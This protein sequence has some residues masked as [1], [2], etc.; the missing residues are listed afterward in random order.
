MLHNKYIRVF[1]K[2]NQQAE[3]PTET[4]LVKSVELGDMFGGLTNKGGGVKS[5]TLKRTLTRPLIAMAHVK[6]LA[7]ECLDEMRVMELPAKGSA[8]GTGK[9]RVIDG[10]N[11]V[12]GEESTLI[13]NEVMASS[14]QKAGFRTLSLKENE[15]K[16]QVE[17]TNE[18]APLKG[19]CFAFKSG[20]I[21][22]GKGYL[23]VDVAEIEV[24]R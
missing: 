19:K 3:V 7:F 2:K 5:F 10:K 11:L 15:E 24:E 9:A 1:A 22:E 20:G 14:L 21:K 18:G 23:S 6:A 8:G 17:S 13:V 12:T 16:V 4:Q